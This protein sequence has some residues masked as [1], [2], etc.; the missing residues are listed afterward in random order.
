[1]EQQNYQI[2]SM[3]SAQTKENT[4]KKKI[5]AA[6]LIGLI[7]G[8]GSFWLLEKDN[9]IVNKTKE[10]ASKSINTE[11]AVSGV[12]L[13]NVKNKIIVHEQ[14][15][16]M[17]VTLLEVVLSQNSWV[18]INED[19]EGVPGN[20]LGAIRLDAGKYSFITVDLLRKMVNGK[21]Y[22]AT[23]RIDDGVTGFDLENDKLLLDIDGN[24]VT[25][26]FTTP[27]LP[28]DKENRI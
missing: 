5:T 25:V 20:I 11:S 4:Q 26:S 18:A 8:F 22:Y 15:A 23:L 24:P 1:M 16:D 6:F 10:T 14:T 7:V 28:K 17:S 2:S 19:T 12:L 27:A 21:K 13:N 3:Q 9:G